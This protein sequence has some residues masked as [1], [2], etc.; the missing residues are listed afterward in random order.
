MARGDSPYSTHFATRKLDYSLNPKKQMRQYKKE[1]LETH[2]ADGMLPYE[3]G[4]LPKY[5][6]DVVDN[7]IMASKSIDEL[8]KNENLVDSEEKYNALKKL[9]ENT[10]KMVI[11]MINNVDKVLEEFTITGR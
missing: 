6:G 2:Y 3:M 9:K 7:G 1:E 8:L 11:Y 10:D 5:F 4:D